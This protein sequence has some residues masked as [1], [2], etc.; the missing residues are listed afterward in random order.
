MKK[1]IS[2]KMENIIKRT[3]Q[4]SLEK[5]LSF[6]F[7][8]LQAEISKKMDGIQN[9]MCLEPKENIVLTGRSTIEQALSSDPKAHLAFAEVGLLS[10]Q[11]CSVRFDETLFEA[12]E[13]YE[14]SLDYLLIALNGLGTSVRT[15]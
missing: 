9:N 5:E 14:F 10:C 6:D 1:W 15:S 11:N 3:F 2:Q 12:A 7:S 4:T 8:S 13:F